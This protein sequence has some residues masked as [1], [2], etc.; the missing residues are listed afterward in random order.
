MDE[1]YLQHHVSEEHSQSNEEVSF[2]LE[3]LG[4]R[5]IPEVLPRRKQQINLDSNL[6]SYSD[7]EPHT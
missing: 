6:D 4:I 3:E 7:Y 5:Q 2:S 1:T